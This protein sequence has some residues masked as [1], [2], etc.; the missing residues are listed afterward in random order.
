MKLRNLNTSRLSFPFAAAIAALSAL[1]SAPPASA[2]TWVPLTAG[3][4]SWDS[5]ANWT[6]PATFVN[7]VGDIA[8]M[9]GNLSTGQT[10][11]LNQTITLGS[12]TVGDSSGTSTTML[13]QGS[14]GSLVFDQTGTGNAFLTRTAGG[15]G[16]VTLNANL[17]ISLKDN[18]VVNTASA[19]T[20]NGIISSDLGIGITKIGTGA[21]T[22]GGTNTYSG[23]TVLGATGSVVSAGTTTVSGTTGT[24]NTSSGYTINGSGSI[25]SLT[26]TAG[27]LD[28]LNDAATVTLNLGGALSLVHNTTNNTTETVANLALGIGSGTVTVSSA[29]SRVTTLA[30]TG[31]LTRTNKATALVRGTSL[32]QSVS[33]NVARIT[34][35]TVP[36][37]S[38][39]VGTNTLSGGGVGDATQSLKIIPWLLGDSSATGTGNNFVTYDSTL[40]L[41]VL[42]VA[43]GTVLTDASTTATDPEN[44][45]GFSGAVTAPDLTVNSLLFRSASQILDGSGALTVNSGA[46]AT[47]SSGAGIGSGFSSLVLGNGEGILTA[48]GSNVLTINTPVNV[49]SSGGLTKNGGGTVI[50]TASNLYTGQTTVNQGILQIGNGTSGDLGTNTADIAVNGGTISLFGN[51][52]D[53]NV[54]NNISG[55][56]GVTLNSPS[57][58]NTLTGTNTYTGTTTVNA[59]TLKSLS[60]TNFG[61]S[62]IGN[63]ALALTG[64]SVFDLN[65][66][67]AAF[68]DVLTTGALS[69]T[70]T[71]SGISDA[72]LTINNASAVIDSVVTDG[73]T[74]K[75]SVVIR[76]NNFG[77]IAFAPGNLNTF[78]GGMTLV[79]GAGLN[80]AGGTR[81]RLNV[82]VAVGATPF[83]SGPITVG[84]AAT[85]KAGIFFDQADN[86]LSNAL[87]INTSLGTDRFGI[88]NDGRLITLSG[89]IT[90]NADL[91][92]SSNST[93]AS[94]TR[95]TNQVTGAGGL[96]IDLSQSGAGIVSTVTLNNT[97]VN[98]NDYSGDTIIGRTNGANLL[99]FTATLALGADDQIPDGAGKGNVFINSN[100]ALSRVGSLNL[101][102]FNETINGLNGNGVVEGGPSGVPTLTVGGGDANGSFSGIIRNTGST[103]SLTKIGN[104]TQTL[105]GAN[106]YTGNTVVNAG[107]LALADN[108]QLKFVLG[109]TSGIN[110]SISGAGTVTLDGD[111]VI[112][113]TA[114][115]ALSSGTWTLEDIPSLSG[116]Y[117][118]TFSVLGF[119]DAGSNKW[120]K[121]SGAKVYTFDETTGILTLETVG[122]YVSWAAIN[123]IGSNPDQDKDGDGVPNAVEYVL[124]GTVTTNDLSKLPHSSISGTNLI[125]TFQRAISSID[126]KTA[127]SVETSNDLVTWNTAPSPYNVPDTA[128]AN[129]PGITVV[130]DTS[131]GFDTVTLIV[132]QAPDT[133]KFVRLKVMITP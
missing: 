15:T 18:L 47:V 95:I 6:N 12:L 33:T 121:T 69:S 23:A 46:V 49:T 67:N 42:T 7:A 4:H 94:N 70:I 8:L 25:L 103:L 1:A 119:V 84:Q 126:T 108:A 77:A 83:G 82:A 66:F 11:N 58:T 19:M 114:A 72:T 14:A 22:L 101:V 97:T 54:V 59:G 41:R 86:T 74:N 89:L 38:D 85:D 51:G 106:T 105:S 36:T 98:A 16:T 13:Q 29:T 122:G 73:P 39:F 43:Q 131:L 128:I 113:T 102:G 62:G 129:N 110:N 107:T 127:V 99:G 87:V 3:P 63:G 45:I 9:N 34:L 30:V 5:N 10:V 60:A 132:P 26:N 100:S 61:A 31:A 112:D 133:K 130:E 125:F 20:I 2:A 120:T 116:A 104:G 17:A 64:T 44:A 37:G 93:T 78:S 76:N 24:I 115:D 91:V 81:L 124:G 96:A 48:T 27:N 40:G 117:G 71:N 88:R 92:F 111:F 68:T 118:S 56:G 109:D 52:L 90:A 79:D 123:A 80:P 55:A 57:S 21:L 50:L 53:L 75:L 65:G 35:G 28:R 32:T